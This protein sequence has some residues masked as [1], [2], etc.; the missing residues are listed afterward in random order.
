MDASH[1]EHFYADEA[2]SNI[3]SAS[4]DHPLK[5]EGAQLSAHE[6]DTD[7]AKLLNRGKNETIGRNPNKSNPEEGTIN[8]MIPDSKVQTSK[9]NEASCEL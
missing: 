3:A 1:I 4:M 8:P 2:K 9:E 6:A 5:H 7:L